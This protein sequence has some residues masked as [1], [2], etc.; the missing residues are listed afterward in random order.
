VGRGATGQ[1]GMA[2]RCDHGLEFLMCLLP[3]PDLLDTRSDI[4]SQRA[5]CQGANYIPNSLFAAAGGSTPPR[6]SRR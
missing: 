6:H 2:G 1:S 5:W 4:P 3:P